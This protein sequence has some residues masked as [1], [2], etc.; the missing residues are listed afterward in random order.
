MKRQQIRLFNTRSVCSG[1]TRIT[2]NY[3]VPLD[4]INVDTIAK[5]KR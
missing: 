3:I 4:E 5:W 1:V 2:V